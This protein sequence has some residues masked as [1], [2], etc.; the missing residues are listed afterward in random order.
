[1]PKKGLGIGVRSSFLDELGG[2]GGVKGV[3]SPSVVALL[4][5]L[6]GVSGGS[7]MSLKSAGDDAGETVD[8]GDNQ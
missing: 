2:V 4:V 1:M 6:V 3:R 5:C 8:A 7:Q